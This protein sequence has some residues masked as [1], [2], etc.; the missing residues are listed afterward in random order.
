VGHYDWKR[1]GYI[2]EMVTP[3]E[4][5]FRMGREQGLTAVLHGLMIRFRGS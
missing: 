4:A 3:S 1:E 2:G 5:S